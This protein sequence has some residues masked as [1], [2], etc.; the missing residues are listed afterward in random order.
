[1]HGNR[2]IKLT[3]VCAAIELVSREGAQSLD[4]IGVRRV[5][6]ISGNARRGVEKVERDLGRTKLRVGKEM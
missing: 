6:E 3:F 4:W 5:G 2:E 1:M